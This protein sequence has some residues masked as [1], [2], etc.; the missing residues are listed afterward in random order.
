MGHPVLSLISSRGCKHHCVYCNSVVMGGGNKNVRYRSTKNIIEEINSTKE[1]SI[2]YRFND[3]HFTGNPNLEDLLIK[4]KDL[5][6][7]FRVFARVEDLNEK[8]S[9]LLKEAGCV[10]VAVG[11][12]SLDP[13]NLQI[14]GK[15]A[16]IGHENNVKLAKSVGLVVRSS[17]MGGLPF[18]TDKGVEDSFKKAAQLGIDEFAIYPLIPYPGTI[19]A[20]FPKKFGYTIEHKN[21]EDYVQMGKDK[22]TCFALKHENFNP[23][24]VKKWFEMATQ[25]LESEGVKH[26]RESEVAK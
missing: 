22:K 26:M 17:F 20:K 7:L 9:R 18:D 4:M 2:Y 14:L 21:F 8:N 19:I 12:E 24:N 10:H 25:I 3:D 11:L 1:S 23:E 5:N 13:S 6:I 16:Q 15:K